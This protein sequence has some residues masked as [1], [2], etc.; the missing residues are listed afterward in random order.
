LHDR[1]FARL[2]IPGAFELGPALDTDLTRI[3][4]Q[5]VPFIA[6]QSSMPYY[7]VLE[8]GSAAAGT[9]LGDGLHLATVVDLAASTACC[10]L[11]HGKSS[12]AML[13]VMQLTHTKS[14]SASRA[15]RTQRSLYLCHDSS[16]AYRCT[17]SGAR[18]PSHSGHATSDRN[19]V[20]ISQLIPSL[21]QSRHVEGVCLHALVRGESGN[22]AT[23]LVSKQTTHSSDL[24]KGRK[25]QVTA[26]VSM[27]LTEEGMGRSAC[28]L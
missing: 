23:S 15:L 16:S 1:L 5:Q 14:L 25:D 22:A 10:A 27:V 4:L 26:M 12:I 7:L 21:T 2:D 9:A 13:D 19:L 28:P 24:A 20:S 11:S 3:S 18:K 6:R 8:A 17:T